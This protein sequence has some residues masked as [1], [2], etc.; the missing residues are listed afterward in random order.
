[1]V[2]PVDPKRCMAEVVGGSFMT[3][4][5][6]PLVRCESIPTWVGREGKREDSD[7]RGE[8]SLCDECKQKCEE[9]CPDVEFETLREWLWRYRA[10]NFFRAVPGL[11]FVRKFLTRTGW[12]S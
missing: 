10:P 7:H 11:E 8:M 6:R 9:Q 3:F 2:D 1:V 4:G 12:R 5:P